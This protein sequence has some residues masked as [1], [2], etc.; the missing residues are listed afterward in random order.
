MDGTSI[1]LAVLAVAFYSP[2]ILN[3]RNRDLSS[4]KR[5]MLLVCTLAAA[6]LIGAA[7]VRQ[8]I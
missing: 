3:G 8:F 2:V 6:V 7:I 1:L 5:A 4:G